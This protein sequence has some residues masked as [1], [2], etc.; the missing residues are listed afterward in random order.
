[1]RGGYPELARSA[2][3]CRQA[4]NLGKVHDAWH[5]QDAHDQERD[6]GHDDDDLVPDARESEGDAVRIR[7]PNRTAVES[8]VGR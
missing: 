5:Y 3:S 1:M 8:L 2:Q 7:S 4:L 6:A